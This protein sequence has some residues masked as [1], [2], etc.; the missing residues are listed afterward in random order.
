[1]K[2]SIVVAFF[3]SALAPA[4]GR[5]AALDEPGRLPAGDRRSGA[6]GVSLFQAAELLD[7]LN[8][9]GARAEWVDDHLE[10]ILSGGTRV[11]CPSLDK[12]YVALAVR[13]TYLGEEN[14]PGKLV[15]DEENLVV[16]STGRDRY[17]EVVWNKEML[18][19]PWRP[20][21]TGSSVELAAGPGVGI[22]YTAEPSKVRVTYYGP[23]AGTRL[24]KTLMEADR[25]LYPL[26]YGVDD[27]TSKPVPP[28][29][30]PGFMTLEER[31]VR[32]WK[33]SPPRSD[34]PET[35]AA[36]KT[37]WWRSGT[38]FV[39]VPDR[40]TLKLD[41]GGRKLRFAETRMK[42]A[43]W[44]GGVETDRSQEE[45]ARHVREHFAEYAE[46]YPAWR[47]LT[48]AAKAVTVVRLLRRQGVAVDEDWARG[49][50]IERIQTAETLTAVNVRFEYDKDGKPLIEK[51]VRP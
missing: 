31:R 35:D 28:P 24:G 32:N 20:A 49:C 37:K 47:E 8:L 39:L 23:I 14:I 13:C 1:M 29:A 27:A 36:A 6:G 19:R 48:E 42:L 43:A 34:R 25:T 46:I 44:T 38:W 26:M 50:P 15:A 9:A 30:I 33:P 41:D 21:P 5:S 2:R 17:G 40:F 16:I 51:Q 11:A 3:I 10:L 7:S 22:L 12:E 18:P 4:I 45:F